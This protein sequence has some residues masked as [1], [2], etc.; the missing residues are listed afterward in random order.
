M[1]SAVIVAILPIV[2]MLLGTVKPTMMWFTSALVMVGTVAMGAIASYVGR[3]AHAPA[4]AIPSTLVVSLPASNL[5]V[6]PVT[7]APGEAV[8]KPPAAS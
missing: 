1:I 8:I 5:G 4:G 2:F 6:V 7:L 3:Y